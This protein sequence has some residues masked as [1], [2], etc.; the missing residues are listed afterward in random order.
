[1]IIDDPISLLFPNIFVRLQGIA[2]R[3][4]VALKLEGFN[5]TGSI[6]LKPAIYMI[7]KLEQT[8]TA[9]PG[10]TT[11]VESSSGN[12]GIAL[13]LVCQRRGYRFICV[14][15]PNASLA[16]VRAMTAYGAEVVVVDKQDCNGGYLH[17]RIA[18]IEELLAK[19]SNCIW[20]DQY[21]NEANELAHYEMTAPE[22]LSEFPAP[23]FLFIG[24][25][26]TGTLMGCAKR[27]R[28]DSPLTRIVAVDPVGSVIFGST[29]ARRLIPGIGSSRCPELLQ[30]HLVPHVVAVSEEQTIRICH[31][32]AR[33]HGLIVG[34]STGSVLAAIRLMSDE[35]P[36]GASVVAISPDF[37]DKYLDTVFNR[38]WVLRNFGF[39]PQHQASVRALA[40]VA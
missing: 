17:T 21:A 36:A 27:F 29:P 2:E 25:G 38:D 11:I 18:Y 9:K 5:I 4:S 40:T 16:S 32:V 6:K 15:D 34:G 30:T 26:S 12:L 3:T 10:E 33:E 24:A 31:E 14:S 1:M 20:L 39:E 13:S 19:D 8:G 22:I 7:D 37:G 28:E 35:I 23:D